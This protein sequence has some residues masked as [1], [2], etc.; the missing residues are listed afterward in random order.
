MVL[1]KK[2]LPPALSAF[3][4]LVDLKF[5]VR[6]SGLGFIFLRRKLG[7][8]SLNYMACHLAHLRQTNLDMRNRFADLE[9]LR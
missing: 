7:G 2:E 1:D 5:E 3:A 9:V 4:L 8:R 6:R